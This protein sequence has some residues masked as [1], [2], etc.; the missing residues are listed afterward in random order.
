MQP[1]QI[2]IGNT[3]LPVF[4]QDGYS[5]KRNKI[6]SKNTK[7]TASGTMV[8]DIVARKYTIAGKWNDLTQTEVSKIA[9]AID[10][11]AFFSVTFPNEY[12][13]EQTRTFYSADPEYPVGVIRN[14]ETLYS[15]VS[16]ELIEK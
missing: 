9:S 14:G 2:I 5:V 12:G 7:R 16:I 13:I 1:K 8:G 6:W 4:A 10:S 15:E 11:S 3:T